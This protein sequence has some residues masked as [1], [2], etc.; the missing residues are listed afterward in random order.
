M[1]KKYCTLIICLNWTLNFRAKIPNK[2]QICLKNN[3]KKYYFFFFFGTKCLF[4]FS[5]ERLFWLFL[6]HF[7]EKVWNMILAG[8][9][10]WSLK[11]VVTEQ[12]QFNHRVEQA[13]PRSLGLQFAGAHPHKEIF[14][15]SHVCPFGNL[16]IA[17]RP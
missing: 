15:Y 10:I 4:T 16:T 13:L 12:E 3:N 17:P 2:V 14:F 6:F 9:K 11:I 1:S 8:L 5:R 7:L